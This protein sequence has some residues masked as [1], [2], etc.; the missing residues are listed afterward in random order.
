MIDSLS[1]LKF[2]KE[3]QSLHLN[4]LRSNRVYFN[5]SC[6]L[7]FNFFFEENSQISYQICFKGRLFG[8]I[9]TLFDPR[10]KYTDAARAQLVSSLFGIITERELSGSLS[11]V[12]CVWL[13]RTV[14]SKCSFL[15]GTRLGV[16]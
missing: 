14:V 4:S 1:R 7:S 15:G 2:F 16:H 11:S 13:R 9:P 3:W 10:L 5:I 6:I 8:M 12:A